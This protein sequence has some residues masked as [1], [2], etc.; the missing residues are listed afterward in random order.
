MTLTGSFLKQ[1]VVQPGEKMCARFSGCMEE[2]GKP[3]PIRFL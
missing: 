3:M 1:T 2:A